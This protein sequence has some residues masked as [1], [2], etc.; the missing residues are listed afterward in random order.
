VK[1]FIGE[2][3]GGARNRLHEVRMDD[4][5]IVDEAK[6]AEEAL[7]KLPGDYNLVISYVCL[8]KMDGIGQDTG[9]HH[10]RL[11]GRGGRRRKQGKKEQGFCRINRSA[12][13]NFSA[14]LKR[15]RKNQ[16]IFSIL[17]SW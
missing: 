9:Y 2:D 10:H 17:P 14:L 7:L 15:G 8:K 13:I 12:F 16:L 4:D 11:W 3:D 1:I 6:S 5:H